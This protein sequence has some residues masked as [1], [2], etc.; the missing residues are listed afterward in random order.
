VQIGENGA[1]GFDPRDPVKR[2]LE[3]EMAWVWI[4]P[5]RIDDPDVEAGKRGYAF[6]GQAFDV[7]GIGDIA[8]AKP[9]GRDISVV[10]QDR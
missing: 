7:G 6:A 2:F 9:E 4:N 8:E 5:K 1:L 10:L 3:I